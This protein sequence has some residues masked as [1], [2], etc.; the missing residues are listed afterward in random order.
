MLD[1]ET[2]GLER[3]DVVIEV[4]VLAKD[5]T[6]LL[7]TFIQ[8]ATP[9]G[10]EAQ[11]LHGIQPEALADAPPFAD[12]W[13]RLRALFSEHPVIFYNAAFDCRMLLHTAK[14]A[15]L[16]IPENWHEH[17]HCLMEMYA[18]FMGGMRSDGSYGWW[19]LRA[20]CE[21]EKIEA[22]YHRAKDDAE[23]ALALLKALAAKEELPERSTRA[24][25]AG[26]EASA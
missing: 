20:A 26:S 2:T 23:A 22:L 7:D 24:L 1:T 10:D 12:V 21:Q 8:T 6:V 19:S 13:P 25:P 17:T 14:Q 5:G 16:S 3:D 11:A 9:I 15:Q 4:A 18:A